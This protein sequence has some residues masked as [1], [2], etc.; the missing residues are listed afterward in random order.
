MKVFEIKHF[1]GVERNTEETRKDF[2][3]LHKL[4]KQDPH[5]WPTEFKRFNLLMIAYHDNKPVAF[6]GIN[7]IC[8]NWYFRGC[9]V[10]P[11]F[12]GNGLQNKLALF[13]YDKLRE[14][15]VKQVTSMAHINNKIS[16]H[17]IEK[18]GM[19]KTGRRKI[20]YHYK[21]IL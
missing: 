2:E 3:T 16:Q 1:F 19:T 15:G 11:E 14:K 17:N 20:N 12:R 5:Y 18:R 13:G 4:Y 7:Q 9:Y 8:G 21:Q 6:S 10:L